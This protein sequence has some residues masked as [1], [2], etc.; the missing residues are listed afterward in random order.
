[1]IKSGRRIDAEPITHQV[2]KPMCYRLFYLILR[3]SRCS[4]LQNG[5][6]V[7]RLTLDVYSFNPRAE[8]TYLKAGF[9]RE[10]VLKDAVKDGDQ[11][12]DDIL[13]AILEDEW[14]ELK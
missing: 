5:L 7:H 6:R 10:G 13:M 12:A 8:K 11:Y 14:R 9:K 1:M 2:K 4:L 3:K